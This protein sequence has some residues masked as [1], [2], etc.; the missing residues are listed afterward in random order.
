MITHSKCAFVICIGVAVFNVGLLAQAPD[1]QWTKTYDG[2][3]YDEGYSVLQTNDGGFLI[4]GNSSSFGMYDKIWL[5]RTDPVG[6]TLWTRVYGQDSSNDGYSIRPTPDSGYI[7]AGIANA[8]T[9]N[10]DFYLLKIDRNGDTLWSRTYGGLSYDEGYN[11]QPTNDGGYIVVGYADSYGTGGDIYAVKTNSLGDTIWTRTYGGGDLD[12]GSAVRETPGGGYII[13]GTKGSYGPSLDDVYLVKINNNGDTVWTRTYGRP[14]N[15]DWGLALDLLPDSGFIVAGW[16][17]PMS[18]TNANVYLLRLK[19]NGDTVWTRV[20]GGADDDYARY[21]QLIPTGG[22]IVTGFTNSY[23]AGQCDVWLLKVN[24]VGDTVWTK[25]VGGVGADAGACVIPTSDQGYIAVGYS[26]S[27]EPGGDVY[28]IKIEPDLA[29]A[30]DNYCSRPDAVRV[31]KTWPNPVR[32]ELAIR[33]HLSGKTDVRLFLYDASGRL[34]LKLADEHQ[35]PGTYLK[36]FTLPD[37]PQG[38]YF[39]TLDADNVRKTEKI[40]L[41]K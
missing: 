24:A 31:L 9:S 22:Y 17:C 16:T 12:F 34:V 11:A 38:V 3:S 25:T 21:V 32:G 18:G 29:V 6:D 1:T 41:M 39:I 7:I 13:A 20:F 23:G 33:Y 36:S 27:F 26:D 37:L 15:L 35:D 28:A 4:L 14:N 40:I 5:I 19:A 10:S 8:A 30:E 2:S